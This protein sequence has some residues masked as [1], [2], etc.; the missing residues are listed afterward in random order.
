MFVSGAEKSVN[1]SWFII[2][3]GAIL[4]SFTG[5][6]LGNRFI[7]LSFLKNSYSI[8][9]STP[10]VLNLKIMVLTFG[11]NFNINIMTI[12]GVIMAIIL[13]RRY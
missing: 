3:L 4:G 7:A 6:I 5:D 1:S 9:M 10:I 11:L 13:Y 2:F 12:I 8:G